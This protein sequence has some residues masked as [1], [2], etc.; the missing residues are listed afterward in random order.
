MIQWWKVQKNIIFYLS[1]ALSI[2]YCSVHTS[3][4]KFLPNVDETK[5]SK[6]DYVVIFLLHNM[7]LVI[8]IITTQ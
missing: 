2:I 7:Y 6:Y 1:M 4:F 3:E 8:N 5:I